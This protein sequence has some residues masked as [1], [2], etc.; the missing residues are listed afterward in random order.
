LLEN[1]ERIDKGL[2]PSLGMA[3][4][5]VLEVIKPTVLSDEDACDQLSLGDTL[6]RQFEYETW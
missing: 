5:M 1:G 2:K 6:S 3:T 4:E